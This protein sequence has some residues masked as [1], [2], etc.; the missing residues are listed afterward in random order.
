MKSYSADVIPADVSTDFNY[1]QF[2]R[3]RVHLLPRGEDPAFIAQLLL[4]CLQERVDVVFPCSSTE[5]VPLS[6]AAASFAASGIKVAVSDNAELLS[7]AIDKVATYDTL[8]KIKGMSSFIPTYKAFVGREGLRQAAEA[9]GYPERDVVF[10]P[11][12]SQGGRGLIIVSAHPDV[13]LNSRGPGALR[14][15]WLRDLIDDGSRQGFLMEYLPGEEYS[16]DVL[17]DRGEVK[18]VVPRQR[19]TVVDGKCAYTKVVRHDELVDC[20]RK[21][22]G[23]FHLSYIANLQFKEDLYGLPK[24]LEVNP[25]VPAGLAMDLASGVNMFEEALNLIYLGEV[26]QRPERWDVPCGRFF[27]ELYQDENNGG[28]GR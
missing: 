11:R 4:L 2:L 17:A 13:F 22:V 21:I 1:N 8:M 28:N 19:L 9:L 27:R 24:L 18:I 15:E 16:V 14:L 7:I 23:A 5:V 20:T 10:K 25:R 3:R 6:R 12:Y 26:T